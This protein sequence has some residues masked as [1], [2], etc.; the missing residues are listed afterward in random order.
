[1]IGERSIWESRR[2]G[3]HVRV[4]MAGSRTGRGF[5]IS[6]IRLHLRLISNLRSD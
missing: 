3:H 5:G 6:L 4:A 2:G 1:M